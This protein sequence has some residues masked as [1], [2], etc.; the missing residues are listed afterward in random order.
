[1][2]GERRPGGHDDDL[3]PALHRTSLP[4]VVRRNRER[5]ATLDA[6]A[7]ERYEKVIEAHLTAHRLALD[8]LE[9]S[10]QW[11]ADNLDLDLVSDTR[12]AAVWQMAGRCIGLARLIL[13]ALALGYTAEVLHLARALHEAN[14]LMD[15]LGDPEEAHILRKWLA[16]EGKEWVR[17]KEVHA[18]EERFD[19]RVAEAMRQAGGPELP[20]TRELTRRL[21]DERSQAAHHRRRWTQDAVLLPLRTMFRGPSAAWIR[22]AATTAAMVAVAE[23]AVE[24][25]GG[26]LAWFFGP[27]WYPEHVKPLLASFEALRE[28]QPLS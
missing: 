27:S 3:Q 9:E 4:E 14:R 21:Y 8:C 26:A 7:R 23:E 16:D 19:Q 11:I 13:D 2:I 28:T 6:A 1:M 15:I 10:H 20:R 5:Q 25:V 22:R 18:A 12:P 24:S 17:P